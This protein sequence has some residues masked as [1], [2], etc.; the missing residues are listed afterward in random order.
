VRIRTFWLI[1]PNYAVTSRSFILFLATVLLP[2][3][4][5]AVV[6]VVLVRQQ[7]ELLERRSE[8]QSL[9]MARE[10]ADSLE[11]R[12]SRFANESIPVFH[13]N[14]FDRYPAGNALLNLGRFQGSTWRPPFNH[15]S[16]SSLRETA[17]QRTIS[18]FRRVEASGR[19]AADLATDYRAAALNSEEPD[20]RAYLFIQEARLLA[21]PTVEARGVLNSGTSLTDEFGIPLAFYAMQ[22]LDE[23]QSTFRTD[24]WLNFESFG[25]ARDVGANEY[26]SGEHELLRFVERAGPSID[27]WTLS[28][29]SNWIINQFE[30]AVLGIRVDSLA[31]LANNLPVTD[32]PATAAIDAAASLAPVFPYLFVSLLPEPRSSSPL[33]LWILALC[34]VLVVT[35]LGSYLLFRDV[36][37]ERHIAELRSRFVSSVSHEVRTPLTAI[38]LY[39]DSLLAYGPGKDEEWRQDLETISYETSRLTRMLDNVLRVSRIERG[40]DQYQRTSGD[41]GLPVRK[42]IEAMMPALTE[43]ECSVESRIDAIPATFDNDAIEQ[44]VVNLLSNASKYAPGSDVHV[45]CRQA[46]DRAIIEVRDGGPGLPAE[47]CQY[48]FDPYYRGDHKATG[49]RTGTGLGLSLVRHIA[50]GHGGDADVISDPGI[51]S[52]FSIHIPIDE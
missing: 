8:D 32:A 33:L 23:G 15:R 51:G 39:T 3:I 4:A 28:P 12:L 9:L 13:D 30:S 43:A 18:Q 31:A 22:V 1:L 24:Q 36:R 2:A 50:R 25:F 42:A 45:A 37:R 29:D 7:A 20:Q 11:A 35:S 47:S 34:L 40:T 41:L 16:T 26:A 52:T 21:E 49:S 17:F 10:V 38:R 19:S 14:P 6:G 5:L 27:T 44:A 48:I 46:E